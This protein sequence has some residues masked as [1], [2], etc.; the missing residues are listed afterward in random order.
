MPFSDDHADL[1]AAVGAMRSG[2][3]PDGRRGTQAS[4]TWPLIC[5][6]E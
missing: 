5:G 1:T 3:N 6:V 2:F 4:S